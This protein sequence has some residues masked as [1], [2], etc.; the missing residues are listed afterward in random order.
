[1]IHYSFKLEKKEH[2]N[3]RAMIEDSIVMTNMMKKMIT[4]NERIYQLTNFGA[5]CNKIEEKIDLED[6]TVLSN[7]STI[8]YPYIVPN[9]SSILISESSLLYEKLMSNR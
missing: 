1:M 4:K 8:I 9:Q 7:M 2:E 6:E 3:F 5:M